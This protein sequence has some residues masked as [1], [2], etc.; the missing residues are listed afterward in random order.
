MDATASSEHLR[1]SQRLAALARTDQARVSVG[2]VVSALGERGFALLVLIFTL[3]NAVPLPAP[4][5]TSAVLALPLILVAAQMML[6]LDQPRLPGWLHRLS[7]PAE[8]LAAVVERA[9]PALERVERRLR[10]RHSALCGS[11]AERLMGLV[12]LVLGL[13]VSLPIPMGNA[14][15]A[16]ALLVLA[17]GLLER[18]GLC[19]LAGLTAG[20]AAVCWNALLVLAGGQAV[21][22]AAEL[23]QD[24]PL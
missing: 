1:M 8:R 15:V 16:W 5:G 14:P 23:F 10:P 19:V 3:P 6:G 17:L 12:C 24:L 2:D 21:A 11:R 13:V 7:I 9:R 22:Y 20:F 18:D 4:P